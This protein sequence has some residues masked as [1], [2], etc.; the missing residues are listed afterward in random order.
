MILCV[1]PPSVPRPVVL[2]S[3]PRP[4]RAVFG[5]VVGVSVVFLVVVV[6]SVVATF[7]VTVS[8]VLAFVVTDSTRQSN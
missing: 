8:V 5:P 3:M 2:D 6:G 4:G 7:V 1:V